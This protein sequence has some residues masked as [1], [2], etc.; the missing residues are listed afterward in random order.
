[1]R[2]ALFLTLFRLIISPIFLVVYLYYKNLG[3]D[4]ATLPYILLGLLSVCELSDIFD[5]VAARHAN[6]VTDLG[7]ILDP[8]ADSLVRVSFLLAF[9]QGV[10]QLPLLLVLV[11][12]YR[13]GLI[14]ALRIVCALRGH[15][16]AARVTGKFKAVVQAVAI[17]AIV[18]MMIPYSHGLMK[19]AD[20]RQVSF[21]I[22]L[23]TAF[24]TMISGIEYVIAN[25]QFIGKAWKKA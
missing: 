2:L 19:L 13:D 15:A 9:T 11:F 10:V 8:I 1:M 22:V 25:R 18:G 4:F 12:V 16:L 6:E 21:Y 24:Y 23:I 7:K 17:F 3:I 14:S 20:F 5:G